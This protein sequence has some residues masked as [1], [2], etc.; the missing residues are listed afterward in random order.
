MATITKK[1]D[2]GIAGGKRYQF[3]LSSENADDG[4]PIAAGDIFMIETS[5]GRPAKYLLITTSAGA[6]VQIRLNT[7]VTTY[8][9][10][11][12]RLNWG[13]VQPDLENPSTRTDTTQAAIAI[14]SSSLF[15][16]DG[17]V[18]VSDI[19]LVVFGYGSFDLFVA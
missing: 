14:D 7:Q 19:Q 11:D 15:E 10:R 1:V 16:L 18:P 13:N 4:T 6:D 3:W 2:T 17:V 9:M 8:P 12:A 5:L